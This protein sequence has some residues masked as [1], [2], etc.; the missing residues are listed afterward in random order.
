MEALTGAPPQG[1]RGHGVVHPGPVPGGRRAGW[2]DCLDVGPGLSIK[3]CPRALRTPG[4][5]G[6]DDRTHHENTYSI[7]KEQAFDKGG[8]A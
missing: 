2:P 7:A 4:L 3:K 8:I 5:M 6:S 1:V